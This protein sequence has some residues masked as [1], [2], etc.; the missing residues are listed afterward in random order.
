VP[1][2]ELTRALELDAELRFLAQLE[3]QADRQMARGLA[4]LWQGDRSLDLGRARPIFF[5]REELGMKESRARWLAR[6]GR[7]LLAVPEIDRA[8]G[9]G[10]ISA[11]QVVVLARI[12]DAATPAEER[13]GWIERATRMTVRGLAKA[14]Q[15]E[16]RRRAEEVAG[17]EVA[18][19]EVGRAPAPEKAAAEDAAEVEATV[20]D[21]T[22]ALPPGGWMTIPATA[23]AALVWQ[24]T[25]ELARKAAGRH[26]TQGQAAEVIFAEYLSAHPDAA[27][28]S[29]GD[30]KGSAGAAEGNG[31]KP[32]QDPLV[33]EVLAALQSGR[34]RLAS[35]SPLPDPVQGDRIQAEEENA[36]PPPGPKVKDPL[37]LPEAY[38]IREEMDPEQLGTTLKRLSAIKR[39]LRYDLAAGLAR[40]HAN[41]DW[42][43]LGFRSLEEYCTTRLGFGVRRGERL[44][45]FHAGLERFPRLKESYRH[46]HLSYTAALLLLPILHPSTEKAW[47]A[48][49]DGEHV[50][51]HW[52][53]GPNRIT[54]R[55][56]ERVA[57][58][59][60]MYA[61]PGASRSVLTSWVKGLAALGRVTGPSGK[62]IRPEEVGG[63][64][65]TAFSVG[66][67][68]PT[69]DSAEE[70]VPT[71]YSLP[72]ARD[73]D[74]PTISGVPPELVFTAPEREVARIRFWL[75]HDALVLAE[76]ALD[77]ARR[78]AK[79]PMRPTSV[80]L[81]II[82]VHFIRTIDNPVAQAY[83]RRHPI[84]MRDGFRCIIPGCMC[85]GN[86]DS[87]HFKP[88]GECGPDDAFN[89]GGECHADH[90]LGVHMG[91]I[92]RGGWA[93]Y[94]VIIKLGIHP[95]T[96]RAFICYINEREVSE[97]VADRE[98][99]K[100]RTW[101][102]EWEAARLRGIELPPPAYVRPLERTGKAA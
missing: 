76:R 86:L 36:P 72:P 92:I 60:R 89:Q 74:L 44:V 53:P 38:V 97:E 98:L 85:R 1:P 3:G 52:K 59:A 25:V 96:G 95:R 7:T 78:N 46:E 33:A 82:L 27:E 102:R 47:I 66:S 83:N 81:E 94:Y 63:N 50:P 30:A 73:G 48:W 68:A 6:M 11:A 84:I 101:L 43:L 64:G 34:A 14:V 4:L 39:T 80:Y 16:K 29:A 42:N 45:R 13:V 19:A 24:E 87:D 17:A 15:A 12:V 90:D 41:G 56:L 8:H 67:C 40:L 2:V 21:A 22:Q 10:R 49:I 69:P 61:L 75:P 54:Y 26:L 35:T 70:R 31:A 23:R 57:E 62:K 51:S 58:Y 88:R 37:P 32:P 79:D 93:P 71:G 5:V 91:R 20:T 9:E 65:A 99:A 28:G 55:E 77:H 18:R 100:W